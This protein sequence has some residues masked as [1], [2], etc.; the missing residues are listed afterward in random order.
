MFT[1]EGMSQESL[2]YT[3]CLTHQLPEDQATP[4]G[5]VCACCKH[6]LYTNPPAGRCMSFWESQP[7]AY[8]LQR[9]PCFVYTL[10]WD[11][12][13]IRSLHPVHSVVDPRSQNRA[14]SVS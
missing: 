5:L 13:R 7:G 14:E 8:T 4:L 2:R 1:I 11:D 6:R 9:E 12:F 3:R 10:I